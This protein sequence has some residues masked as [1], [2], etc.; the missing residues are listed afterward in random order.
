MLKLTNIVQL[1]QEQIIREVYMGSVFKIFSVAK[2][3]KNNSLYNK[4]YTKERIWL[5]EQKDAKEKWKVFDLIE[6]YKIF[7]LCKIWLL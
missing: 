5:Y 3:W 7:T 4:G 2:T 6:W 1:C